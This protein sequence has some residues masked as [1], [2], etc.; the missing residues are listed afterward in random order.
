MMTK[1][2]NKIAVGSAVASII[3]IIIVWLQKKKKNKCLV[4]I[5]IIHKLQYML[6]IKYTC[7][8]HFI[9]CNI[10]VNELSTM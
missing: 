5:K 4:R 2:P 1:Q 7:K 6:Q 3:I 8:T 9:N 10:H